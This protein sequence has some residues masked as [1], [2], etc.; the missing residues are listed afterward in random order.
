M[1]VTVLYCIQIFTYVVACHRILFYFKAPQYSTA[2]KFHYPPMDIE[3]FTLSSPISVVSTTTMKWAGMCPVNFDEISDIVRKKTGDIHIRYPWRDTSQ[4]IPDKGDLQK[5]WETQG[6]RV[7]NQCWMLDALPP[8]A[9]PSPWR[10]TLPLMRL[11]GWFQL[12]E[13]D[14]I[15]DAKNELS[16]ECQ[17][18]LPS[19]DCGFQ[20]S[21]S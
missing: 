2:Y 13:G 3:T 8:W 15:R 9:W 18:N 11:S 6:P 16:H 7:Q 5:Q 14:K 12:R 19:M 21:Y 4:R 1:I 20:R 10:P 17:P